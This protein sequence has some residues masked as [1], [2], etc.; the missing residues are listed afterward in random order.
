M[1]IDVLEYRRFK[2]FIDIGILLLI[3]IRILFIAEILP[4][5]SPNI[6]VTA[7]QFFLR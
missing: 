1:N 5:K 2:S 3:G 4:T 7:I 6:P